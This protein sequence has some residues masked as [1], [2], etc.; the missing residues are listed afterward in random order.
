[1]EGGAALRRTEPR[2]RTVDVD[3][4]AIGRDLAVFHRDRVGPDVL[5][6]PEA[7]DVLDRAHGIELARAHRRGT[8]HRWCDGCVDPSELTARFESCHEV[9]DARCF[10]GSLGRE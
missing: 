5:D 7:H 6:V 2:G 3:L 10:S 1:L 9:V 4:T 8:E